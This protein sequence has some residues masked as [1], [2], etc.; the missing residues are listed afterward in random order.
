M[1]AIYDFIKKIVLGNEPNA[2]D[3][4]NVLDFIVGLFK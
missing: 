1:E 4:F 3:E 2:E